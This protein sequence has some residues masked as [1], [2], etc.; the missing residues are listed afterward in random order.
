MSKKIDLQ[1]TFNTAHHDIPENKGQHN[2]SVPEPPEWMATCYYNCILW[3]YQLKHGGGAGESKWSCRM[4]LV[5]LLDIIASAFGV[6][7][8]FS[9]IRILQHQHAFFVS[10]VLYPTAFVF[11]I[12]PC[13]ALYYL[14]YK[15]QAIARE[16]AHKRNLYGEAN[17]SSN[18]TNSYEM[19]YPLKT[20]KHDSSGSDDSS[21]YS[22]LL[23][24]APKTFN[25]LNSFCERLCVSACLPLNK[26]SKRLKK[27][28]SYV[29]MAIADSICGLLSILPII[30]LSPTLLTLFGQISLPLNMFAAFLLLKR[31]F[32]AVQNLCVVIII[33][34][35]FI[36]LFPTIYHELII[37]NSN[38]TFNITST[39]YTSATNESM[40]E[41]N[42]HGIR[43]NVNTDSS[44]PMSVPIPI[45]HAD[46]TPNWILLL[47]INLLSR[48]IGTLSS[49]F[50]ER[51]MKDYKMEPVLTV[52][53]VA[54]IQLPLSYLSLGY[55]LLPLPFKGFG[56]KTAHEIWVYFLNSWN[57]LLDSQNKCSY[58]SNFTMITNN[59]SSTLLGLASP[60]TITT[61]ADID[62]INDRTLCHIIPIFMLFLG[63]NIIT[64]IFDMLIIRDRDSTINIICGIGTVVVS[65]FLF[66]FEAVAGSAYTP[67]GVHVIMALILICIA[68][69]TYSAYTPTERKKRVIKTTVYED[70][71]VEED[72]MGTD[73]VDHNDNENKK[74][75]QS[76][77]TSTT[78]PNTPPNSSYES[79]NINNNDGLDDTDDDDDDDDDEDTDKKPHHQTVSDTTT[80]NTTRRYSLSN[81]RLSLIGPHSSYAATPTA[82]LL[83]KSDSYTDVTVT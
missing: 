14:L 33:S 10:Q 41:N 47:A 44:P 28:L 60:P 56:T 76:V 39:K 5:M 24:P 12:W 29:V 77:S 20:R 26:L 13:T 37:S 6:V 67:I 54:T 72:S 63:I 68:V 11:I 75:P 16:K 9:I 50:K 81:S 40:I 1:S 46:Y 25:K 59:T 64:N 22:D 55:L 43:D 71:E 78:N 2:S 32:N 38:T 48:I 7:I 69:P 3:F 21:S 34:A 17:V 51:V 15:F 19:G 66:S 79:N 74:E 42:T 35:I 58:N 8:W 30:Y 31:R 36:V 73:K 49:I 61:A 82:T 4:M 53:I 23:Q 83:L 57:V 70:Y 27:R 45:H 62:S 18:G 52:S 80:S 65:I